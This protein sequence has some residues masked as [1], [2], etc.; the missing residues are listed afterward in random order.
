MANLKV[1][2]GYDSRLDTDYRVL[3]SSIERFTP[4][5]IDIIP[6]KLDDLKGIFIN[7][8]KGASEFSFSRFLVPYL[9]DYKGWSLFMDC[10][11]LCRV[12]LMEIWK[13]IKA[14]SSK[15]VFVCKHD[16]TPKTTNKAMGTQ[17]SY[18]KKNWSSFIIFNNKKCKMLSLRY[19]NKATG[20]QLHQFEWVSEREI[21]SLP[22][23]WNWLVGEYKK[24]SA[25]KML[26]YT[27][28]T[29]YH[30]KYKDCDCAKEWLDELLWMG[31]VQ[32]VVKISKIK[33][34]LNNIKKLFKQCISFFK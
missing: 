20:K 25:A 21:G 17:A 18:P 16:Y 31:G 30:D 6:L 3:R 26:H 34:F 27:L 7:S 14:D 28:G 5:G 12:D 1:F 22:L 15:T 10:D 9:S 32:P 23:E 2:I 13:E 29:P 11:M 8:S 24:N 4:Y 19:V 33:V